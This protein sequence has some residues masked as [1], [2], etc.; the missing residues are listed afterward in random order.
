[1]LFKYSVNLM[2]EK[3]VTILCTIL[4]SVDAIKL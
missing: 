2:R 3:Q 4:S 1:M